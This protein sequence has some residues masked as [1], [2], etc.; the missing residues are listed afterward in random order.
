MVTNLGCKGLEAKLTDCAGDW[1]ATRKLSDLKTCPKAKTHTKWAAVV[2]FTQCKLHQYVKSG[3]CVACPTGWITRDVKKHRVQK[4]KNTSC[5]P[6]PCTPYQVAYS[7]YASS[8]SMKGPFLQ[9]ILVKCNA[10]WSGGGT[11]MC[12]NTQK[13]TGN[14][15]KINSCRYKNV[16]YSNYKSSCMNGIINQMFTVRCD[17]GY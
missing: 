7:N 1:R 16:S 10:G 5:D 9:K 17:N 14:T 11:W 3:K 8:K 15:C 6:G 13:F 4:G 2:C 12:Q